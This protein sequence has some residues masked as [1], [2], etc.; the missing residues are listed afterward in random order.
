[1]K[2][3]TTTRW[4]T[5]AA[6]MLM[7]ALVGQ[8]AAAALIDFETTPA[9]VAPVDDAPL[10]SGTPYSFPGLQVS[11]GFDL[12]SNG[13]IDSDGLFELAG[14]SGLDTIGGFQ[15]S[16]GQDTADT[17][18]AGQLGQWFLKSPM[19]GQQFGRF[20]I[21]YSSSFP[22][23][24]ASG[25]I[26]DIDG[27]P[28]NSTTEEYTVQAFDSSSTL[29]S[30]IVSPLG[31]LDTFSAPLDGQPW[32][33]AF[34]G[35]SAGIDHI[36]ITF[37]GT[38]PAGIGLAFNNFNPTAIP[39][40]EPTALALFGG[41]VFLGLLGTRWRRS[42][43]KLLLVLV[44]STVAAGATNANAAIVYDNLDPTPSPFLYANFGSWTGSFT[45]T[46]YATTSTTFVPSASGP[47]DS[48]DLG[49]TV[50]NN[51]GSQV[52]MVTL[53]DDN[54]GAPGTQLWQS[55]LN[56]PLSFGQLAQLTNIGGPTI[57]MGQTYWLTAAPANDNFTLHGW[58]SNNQGDNGAIISAGTPFSSA[59]RFALRVGVKT[60]PEPA[61]G[62]MLAIAALGVCCGWR[63]RRSGKGAAWAGL[64]ATAMMVAVASAPQSASAGPIVDYNIPQAGG[65]FTF[66]TPSG[67]A[68]GITASNLTTTGVNPLT[69][70]NHFYHH[71]WNT[72]VNT[73]KYYQN[74]LNVASGKTLYLDD[75]S[76]SVEATQAPS[77]F[78]V[79]SS[80]DGF[81]SIVD[82]FTSNGVAV[83]NRITNL[84][85]LGPISG[86]VSFRFYA[87]APNPGQRMGFANHLPGGAGAGSEMPGRNIRFSGRVVPEPASWMLTFGG[88]A[89]LLGRLR[90]RAR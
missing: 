16:N 19:P 85:S 80:L 25:E 89:G 46:T 37:T 27:Q 87:T 28:Q 50:Q 1:M 2:A 15:G 29:L 62:A 57:N 65:G 40:P 64:V 45:S 34:S 54:A 55:A 26:W 82:S 90:M 18:Y 9:G 11:F 86:S 10:P 61:S 32:V 77:T 8:M 81:T 35:L 7:A 72:T 63:G 71:L 13:S 24:A 68:P 48:L 12:D 56:V 47:L 52:G 44:A 70:S 58:Y 6:T 79:R 14:S 88:L 84:M 39:V 31:V 3:R 53:F 33:F 38:K 22:V 30:T 60:V 17:G 66:L 75:V 76:Y 59:L 42:N 83:T 5:A 67:V 41:A 23:T 4:M 78:Q 20:V 21:Q 36:V 43:V 69:F 49:I 74:T 73:G 51:G